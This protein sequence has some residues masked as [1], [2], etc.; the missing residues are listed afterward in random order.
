MS[1]SELALLLAG[2]PGHPHH[3]IFAKMRVVVMPLDNRVK[4]TDQRHSSEI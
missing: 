4:G 1:L 3:N 2:V